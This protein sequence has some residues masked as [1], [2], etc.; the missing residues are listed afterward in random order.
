MTKEEEME[1]NK[2]ISRLKKCAACGKL[3]YHDK[4]LC[5]ACKQ[6]MNELGITMEV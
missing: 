5:G 6:K 4:P 1:Y 3:L 2:L